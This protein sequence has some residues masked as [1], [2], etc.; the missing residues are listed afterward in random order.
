MIDNLNKFAKGGKNALFRLILAKFDLNAKQ[1]KG[2]RD[3]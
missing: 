3:I 2:V 1:I